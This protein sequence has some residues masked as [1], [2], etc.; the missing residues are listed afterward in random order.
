MTSV[1]DYNL[2]EDDTLWAHFVECWAHGFSYEQSCS[3]G[4]T[5]PRRTFNVAME[6]CDDDFDAYLYEH[7]RDDWRRGQG[8]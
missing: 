4:F 1:F 7:H 6:A 5:F 8:L 2:G 3:Y